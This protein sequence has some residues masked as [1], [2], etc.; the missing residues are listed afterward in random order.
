MLDPHR[1]GRR[2]ALADGAAQG[3]A[4]PPVQAA[5][6]LQLCRPPAHRQIHG[7]WGLPVQPGGDKS[8]VELLLALARQEPGWRAFSAAWRRWWTRWGRGAATRPAPLCFSTIHAS[9]GLEYDR[10][11]LIDAVD[12]IFPSVNPGRET[13]CPTRSGR[14]WRRS[15][16]SSTWGATGPGGSL[17]CSPVTTAFGE[18]SPPGL[19]SWGSFWHAGWASQRPRTP[20][21]APAELDAAAVAAWGRR[22]HL[23]GTVV[24]H[25]AS[26]RHGGSAPAVAVIAFDE[27]GTQKVEL[28]ACLRKR[29]PAGL[30]PRLEDLLPI[31]TI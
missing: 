11:F 5:P 20:G 4:H 15:G 30:R 2:R 6:A 21:K 23:P 10:V 9:K 18:P 24:G 19:P 3:P 26:A 7:L 12:G 16:G 17:F 25:R 13:T 14:P 22:D 29:F 28:T 27:V 1:R 31:F 8:R